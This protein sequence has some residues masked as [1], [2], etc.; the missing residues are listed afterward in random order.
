V[1]K[2]YGFD[3]H[4]PLYRERGTSLICLQG[5]KHSNLPC[6]FP[7]EFIALILIPGNLESGDAH[8]A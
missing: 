6:S 2:N 7:R 5:I 1:S 8:G 4:S 3:M